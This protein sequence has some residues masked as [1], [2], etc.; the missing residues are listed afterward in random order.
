[1]TGAFVKG[2]ELRSTERTRTRTE[3]CPCLWLLALLW[4]IAY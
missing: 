1:M 2:N 3:L 4:F